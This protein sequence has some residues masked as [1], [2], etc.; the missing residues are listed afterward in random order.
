MRHAMARHSPV[1]LRDTLADRL[2]KRTWAEIL[3]GNIRHNYN[4][5][6]AAIPARCKFL[7]VVK[8]DAYGHGAEAVASVLQECGADYLAVACIDEAIALREAGIVLPILILGYTSP[9]YTTDLIKYDITQSVA[10]LE[11]ATGYSQAAAAAGK[12]LKIHIKLDTGMS[13]LGF[14]AANEAEVEDAAA[15]CSLP[16]LRHEGIFTHF[17]VSDVLDDESRSF[18]LKQYELFVS[19]INTLRDK[20]GISFTIRH[21]ANSGAVV[22]YPEMAL[23]MVRP[24][25]LLYGYG[26]NT[27]RL[28]LK[29]CMR[30]VTTV[31]A[32]KTY[33]PGVSI[34]YGRRFTTECESKIAVLAAGYADGLPRAASGRVSFHTEK[35]PLPQ[36]GTICMDMCMADASAAPSLEAG[37]EVELFGENCSLESLAEAA[38]TITYELLCGVAKRVPRIY[39]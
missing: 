19:T 21:C 10:D 27:G 28:N 29:P 32:V 14:Q 4:S 38:G 35:G 17:A 16:C 5:I 6:R 3:P 34:S 37:D 15:A 33:G 22:N 25:L 12:E 13:R 7:G 11:T 30:F 26:D 31:S 39:R 23:D 9:E 24:G 8:A 36:V 18:T 1:C 20:Y 2:H